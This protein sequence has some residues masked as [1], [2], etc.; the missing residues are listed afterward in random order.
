MTDT[1]SLRYR[2]YFKDLRPALQKPKVK[3]YTM[4]IFSLLVLSSFSFF[5]IRPTVETILELNRKIKDYQTLNR[6]LDEKIKN[7]QQAQRNYQEI[8]PEIPIV[9][10]AL[11]QQP[12]FPPFLKDLESMASGSGAMVDSLKFQKIN[13]TPQL[14]ASGS[15]QAAQA[16]IKFDLGFIGGYTEFLAFLNKTGQLKRLVNFE[17]FS[18]EAG[19]GGSASGELNM[20]LKGT[21]YFFLKQK[22]E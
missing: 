10:A 20:S 4:L 6:K 18:L 16:N 1:T 19:K 17:S 12:D 9:L 8:Q 15:S 7:L 5:V 14:Q 3:A 21:T 11:P 2:K 13:L 22:G